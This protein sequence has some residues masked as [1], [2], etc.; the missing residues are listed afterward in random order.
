LVLVGN[1][2][3]SPGLSDL[4]TTRIAANLLV[5]TLEGLAVDH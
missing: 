3:S 5:E 1:H 4:G 2:L